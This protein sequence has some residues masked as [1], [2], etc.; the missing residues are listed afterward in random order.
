MSSLT[1][2]LALLAQGGRAQAPVALGTPAQEAP[3]GNVPGLSLSLFPLWPRY[4]YYGI[5]VKESSQYYDVMYS[6]KGAAWVSET[7]KKEVSKQTVAYSPR[8]KLGTLLPE[9]PNVKDL[10]LPASLPEEKVITSKGFRGGWFI[11]IFFTPH[12]HTTHTHTHT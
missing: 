1:R 7:G 3:P 9:F 8:S 5:A 2:E 11:A 6:K 12:T 4:H 10:N